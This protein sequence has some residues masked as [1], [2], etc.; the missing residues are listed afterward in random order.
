MIYTDGTHLI[1]DHSPEE[2]HRFAQGIGL[3]REWFQDHRRPHYD[4]LS[5]QIRKRALRAG[6]MMVGRKQ[7][8][9]IM[10]AGE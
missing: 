2:L 1:S 8:V 4:I 7:L 5:S 9:R 10:K 6:A 3:R